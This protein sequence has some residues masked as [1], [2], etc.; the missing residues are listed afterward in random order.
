MQNTSYQPKAS[1]SYWVAA[2][3]CHIKYYGIRSATLAIPPPPHNSP[4]SHLLLFAQPI[5]PPTLA[6]PVFD[7]LPFLSFHIHHH[8]DLRTLQK[9]LPVSIPLP[10]YH[11]LDNRI[12]IPL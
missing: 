7:L 5:C 8:A 12:H 1:C 2:A 4:R 11:D 9:G 10:L 3:Q 6:L